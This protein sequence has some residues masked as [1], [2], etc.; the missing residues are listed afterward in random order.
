MHGAAAAVR[1]LGETGRQGDAQ[2]RDLAFH[3]VGGSI[4]PWFDH[5]PFYPLDHP[6]THLA[7]ALQVLAVDDNLLN[8][9]D[10]QDGQIPPVFR[11]AEGAVAVVRV[12]GGF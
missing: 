10:R 5:Q 6:P 8:V 11:C 2:N 7:A 9:T 3:N 1:Q 12:V 4:E